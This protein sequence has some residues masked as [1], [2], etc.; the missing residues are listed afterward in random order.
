MTAPVRLWYALQ[1]DAF[2]ETV[3]FYRD[4]LALPIVDGWRDDRSRALLPRDIRP[5]LPWSC[6]T[7]TV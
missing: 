4:A 1:V 7:A 3:A 6:A 2:E 5:A